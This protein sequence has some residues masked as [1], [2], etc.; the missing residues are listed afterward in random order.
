[1]CY[2]A[3]HGRIKI[4]TSG[5]FC[6][7]TITKVL[8]KDSG[9]W[10]LTIGEG[11]HLKDFEKNTFAYPVSVKGIIQHLLHLNTHFDFLTQCKIL[12]NL[13]FYTL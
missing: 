2:S 7:V 1:M 10:H 8:P 6:A 12:E 3:D 11:E 4:T 13:I 5:V 9:D